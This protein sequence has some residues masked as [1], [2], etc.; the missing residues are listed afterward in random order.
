MT[1][2]RGLLPF[3]SPSNAYDRSLV[4][5]FRHGSDRPALVPRR[6]GARHAE[7]ELVI[8][9]ETAKALGRVT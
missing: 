3:G 7:P 9:L 2:V 4:E 8:N 5:T 1:I 6:I